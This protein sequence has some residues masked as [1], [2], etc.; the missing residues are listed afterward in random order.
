[1]SYSA[2][3]NIFDSSN[4]NTESETKKTDILENPET[5]SDKNSASSELSKTSDI[6]NLIDQLENKNK[7]DADGQNANKS[8]VSGEK[9]FKD[10]Q[11]DA[12]KGVSNDSGNNNG[13][14]NVG[15]DTQGK[16]ANNSQDDSSKQTDS[17][18]SC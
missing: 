5:W 10:S 1:M 9:S 4:S 7:F 12:I 18:K 17:Y 8:N 13:I 6:N 3:Y 2:S 11:K 14:N 16:N 15:S